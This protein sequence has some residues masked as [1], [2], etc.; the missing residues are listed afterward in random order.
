MLIDFVELDKTTQ[1]EIIKCY[2][3]VFA[4]DDGKVILSD[5]ASRFK[6]LSCSFM[7]NINETVFNE[8]QRN[9]VLFMLNMI[10]T[11]L[12]AIR[13]EG[14]SNGEDDEL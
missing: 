13:A 9:V 7:G 2:K 4:S 6:M 1:E 8:G 12:D 10:N 14:Q 5:L 3:R 11:D